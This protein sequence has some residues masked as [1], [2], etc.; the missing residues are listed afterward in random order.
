VLQR[1]GRRESWRAG[2]CVRRDWP[3]GTH[4]YVRFYPTRAEA[5]WATL[6]DWAYWRRSHYRP[7]CSMVEISGRDF[8]L[9]GR[10][11]DCRA[12]DCPLGSDP[13]VLLE[14]HFR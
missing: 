1:A 6:A 13:R 7:S 14:G 11:R 3:D 9:H 10:R 5:G 4:E 2:F 12:P 8:R